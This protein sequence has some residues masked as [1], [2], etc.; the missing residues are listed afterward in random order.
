MSAKR[1]EKTGADLPTVEAAIDRML[2]EFPF[3]DYVAAGKSARGTYR[4]IAGTALRHLAPG[5]RILDAGCGPCDKTAVL[6]HLGF[7]CAAYDDLQDAWHGDPGA[8]EQILAWTERCGIDFR[9]ADAGS[10][11]FAAG[12]FDMIMLHDVLEHLHDS[13]RS[14]LTDLLALARPGGLLF[15]T[16]PNAA[17]IRK[18]IALLRGG[19]NL[20]PFAD[21]YWYPGPWRGHVREYVRADLLQLAA[22]LDLEILELRSCDHMLRRVPRAARSAYLLLSSVFRGWKDTWL[23]VAKKRPDWK[24]PTADPRLD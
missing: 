1:S 12:S 17:N 9:V 5:A 14:L 7:R 19:T 20:P 4:N 18:R 6:Q 21:Y 3:G 8:R 23:L 13:P 10:P 11:P 2:A 22:Y 15:V 24:P 16:V